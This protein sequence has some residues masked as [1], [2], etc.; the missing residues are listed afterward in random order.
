MASG[1]AIDEQRKRIWETTDDVLKQER[2]TVKQSVVMPQSTNGRLDFLP[3][4]LSPLA[5][6]TDTDEDVYDY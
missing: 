2:I 6:G 4:T 1:D 3:G 5:Y